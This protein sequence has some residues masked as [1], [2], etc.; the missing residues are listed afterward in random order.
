MVWA[1]LEGDLFIDSESFRVHACVCRKLT[2]MMRVELS[3]AAWCCAGRSGYVLL[4][5]LRMYEGAKLHLE[6]VRASI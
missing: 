5:K 3:A 6:E 4:G 1:E 2:P